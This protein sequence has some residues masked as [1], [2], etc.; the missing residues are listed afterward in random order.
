MG[1]SGSAGGPGDGRPPSSVDANAHEYAG[2]TAD[3]APWA[4]E[5]ISPEAVRLTLE[6][7]LPSRDGMAVHAVRLLGG[8]L[9]VFDEGDLAREVDVGL[10]DKLRLFVT[11]LHSLV[12]LLPAG[13]TLGL[14]WN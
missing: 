11:Q 1:G 14:R 5:G 13:A 7:N 3:F 10:L 2:V 12:E 8:A 4:A 9:L 6:R